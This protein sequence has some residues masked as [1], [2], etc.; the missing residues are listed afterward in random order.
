MKT[1]PIFPRRKPQIVF[2]TSR[3][4][5]RVEPSIVNRKSFVAGSDQRDIYN[6]SLLG[7]FLR[8]EMRF[9]KDGSGTRVDKGIHTAWMQTGGDGCAKIAPRL[10]GLWGHNGL[11]DM[12]EMRLFAWDLYRA[13][14]EAEEAGT[15]SRHAADILIGKY[16]RWC[17]FARGTKPQLV[18]PR[19]GDMWSPTRPDPQGVREAYPDI[20]LAMEGEPMKPQLPSCD[21]WEE[22]LMTAMNK[23]YELVMLR[24]KDK[25]V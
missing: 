10:I 21:V 17:E 18:P 15:P 2:F 23:G 24:R 7:T 5:E 4:L 16:K 3:F 20:L 6:D 14:R 22:M 11:T 12:E 13:A 9:H 8:L 25:R 19:A 1:K